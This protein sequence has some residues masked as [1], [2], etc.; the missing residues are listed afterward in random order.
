MHFFVG[1]LNWYFAD[2]K[3][4]RLSFLRIS[5]SIV[6]LL[7]LMD[8]YPFIEIFFGPNGPANPISSSRIFLDPLNLFTLIGYKVSV[9]TWFHFLIVINFFL[10]VGFFSRLSFLILFINLIFIQERAIYS[11]YGADY[12][13]KMLS[14]WLFFLDLGQNFSIDKLIRNKIRLM[15][16]ISLKTNKYLNHG[17]AIRSAQI[18]LF[19][20]YLTATFTKLLSP[21]WLSGDA[22]FFAMQVP[23]TNSG[24]FNW[25][26]N[27]PILYKLISWITILLEAT[28]TSFIFSQ[29]F[30]LIAVISALILHFG[31]FITMNIPFFFPV[32]LF[33]IAL[34]IENDLF[35]RF[36][37]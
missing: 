6:Y 20:I 12:M 11:M 19:L 9:K 22:V 32:S 16:S 21:I 33:G 35:K 29:N 24:L 5:F 28:I 18:Q 4:F 30:K 36:S 3:N 13:F 34:L 15:N 1:I 7:M 10:L 23:Q 31:I 25:I 14:I 2:L 8:F 27:Y 37:N 17:F 26:L